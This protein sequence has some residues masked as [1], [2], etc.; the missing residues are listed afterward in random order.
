MEHPDWSAFMAAILADPDDDT[1]RLVAAD[2]LEENGDPDRAT[3]IRI[4]CE[5]ARLEAHG[6]A[7]SP[8][9]DELRK[10][11]RAFLG[12]RSVFRL[13][14][15]ADACPELVPIKP[16][17]RGASPLAMPQVEGA[18]KLT[19]RRG[20]V[21]RVHCPVAEWLRHG[22]AVRARQPVRVVSFSTSAHHIAR[23]LWYTN[24]AALRGLRELWMSAVLP[25]EGEFVS[26]L[27]QQLP[28]T[29]VV[30]VPF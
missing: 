27:N 15:A 28:G 14:W 17:P 12:A 10:K 9:A 22:A 2:F 26:W 24:F 21:E 11:E 1:V 25:E 16:P 30:G 18:E 4:Q 29:K 5:L 3:F 13:L 19:W 20:F 23:D 8:E 7:V 6:A